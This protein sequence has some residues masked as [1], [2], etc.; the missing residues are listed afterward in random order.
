[1]SE[2]STA[3]IR[4]HVDTVFRQ[5]SGRILATLI[6]LLGTFDVA[7]DAMHDAFSAALQRW[8]MEGLPANPRAWLISTARFK[9]I[10]AIRRRA[11]FDASQADIADTLHGGLSAMVDRPA[12]AG[13]D[14]LPD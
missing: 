9:A 14:E 1:M 12:T 2:Q 8:P 11:R 7:E 13:D 6:R 4:S 3:E 5:E 10:D